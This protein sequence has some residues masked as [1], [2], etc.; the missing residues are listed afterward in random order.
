M[1]NDPRLQRLLTQ[2]FR[3]TSCDDLHVGIF[4]IAFPSPMYW[5]GS[6]EKEPDEAVESAL[7]AGRDILTKNFCLDGE[8]RFVRG[9]I[10]FKISDRDETFAFGVWGS[11]SPQSFRQYLDH[12]F[13]REAELMSP[14][15]S[16]L[17]NRLPQSEDRPVKCRLHPR[18]R[19]DRP[20]LEIGEEDHPFFSAQKVGLSVDRLLEIYA[21]SGHDLRDALD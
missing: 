9:I 12:F 15:F 20:I 2:G 6:K 7:T 18:P 17:S 10:P 13:A 16:W 8:H 1:S 11:L 4:D 21:S 3:C 19:P 5:A 14:A